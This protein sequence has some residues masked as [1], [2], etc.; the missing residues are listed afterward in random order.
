MRC[1]LDFKTNCNDVI[2]VQRD[3]VID[4][5][6]K[7]LLEPQKHDQNKKKKNGGELLT[8]RLP[9]QTPEC[10]MRAHVFDVVCMQRRA[11]GV[12]NG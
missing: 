7:K 2:A 8:S 4:F 5:I 3:L 11:D 1:A 6:A 12:N 10:E 9:L